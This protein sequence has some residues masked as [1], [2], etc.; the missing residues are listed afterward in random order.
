MTEL[1]PLKDRLA[2]AAFVELLLAP[3]DATDF[4]A[5]H[6]L[7]I[8]QKAEKEKQRVQAYLDTRRTSRKAKNGHPTAPA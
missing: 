3:A 5:A 1:M 8:Y 7:L 2:W 6:R 4:P